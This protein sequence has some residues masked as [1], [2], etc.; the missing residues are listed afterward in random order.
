MNRN[1]IHKRLSHL[2]MKVEKP[3]RY[4][5]G[6]FNQVYKEPDLTPVR[7][8]FAFADLYEIG[9]SY[10]GLQIIYNLLNQEEG[11]ACE[12]VFA[13]GK[14]MEELMRQENVP[15]FTLETTS[16]IKEFDFF[17]F[18]LQYEMAY[19]NILN[20]LDLA[21]IPFHSEDR[22]EEYP[23]ICGGGPCAYN[24][25][26]L[27]PFFDLFMIGDGEDILPQLCHLKKETSGKREFLEKAA[28]LRGVYVPAFYDVTYND[29]GTVKAYTKN[30]Q[31]APDVVTRQIVSNLEEAAFPEEPLVP[32]IETTQ[33]RAVVETFRGCTRGCRFCQAGMIY[34]PIRERTAGK[35]NQLATAQ[36]ANTGHEE[37]SLLSLSTS[38]HSQFKEM[39][40]GL[41]ETCSARDISLSLPSLRLD[42]FSFD[43]LNEIQKYKKSGLTFAPEAGTQR[44]RDVIN[45]N[46]TEDDIYSAM[47]QA[48]ELGWKKI[49]L[50]FMMGLPGETLEDLAGIADIAKKI[51]DINY[52]VNGRKGGRFT[53]TVSVSNFVPK[54]FTPFQWVSQDRDFYEKHNLLREQLKKIKGVQ[55]HYHDS[56]VS[57]LEAIFARGDRRTANLLETAVRKGCTFDSW[58]EQFKWDLWQ[59]AIVETGT[60]VAFYTT[61]QRSLTEVFPW[62]IINC[63]VTK[64]YFKREYQKAMDAVTTP[65][66][67]EGCTGCGMNRYTV[68]QFDG[69]NKKKREKEI[70]CECI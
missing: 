68:C 67:R 21:E 55:F 5:G 50:Y 48:I 44:M 25:E 34:R 6:E 2:L 15:L 24:P 14:D 56:P 9:M 23:I 18:T 37:L 35:V 8:A 1:E 57:T 26:P 13:P 33:D 11:I 41:L 51:M 10:V 69:I 59:E 38:D 19:T 47:R 45:K 58:S 65:D 12:R 29:D 4:I 32:L 42:S 49:K 39:A 22:G 43:V 62:D 7:F 46:I 60:D 61:R 28:T 16:D 17:A 53:V 66:C 36:L 20:M 70:G 3:G 27:A 54:P 30:F 31:G 64:E 63:G 40:V 52:E